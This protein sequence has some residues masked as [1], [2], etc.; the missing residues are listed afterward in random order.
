M[1]CV[2]CNL[3]G[4]RRKATKGK[5]CQKHYEDGKALK[6]VTVIPL[7]D[8]Y[9]SLMGR[10][11]NKKW[12]IYAHYGAK[13][14]TVDPRWHERDAFVTWGKQQGYRKG[15]KLHVEGTVYGPDTCRF[16]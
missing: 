14:Y 11:Y 5:V 10:C 4:V 2:K 12:K 9:Y 1:L 15:M 13:G 6:R 8:Y 7:R 3:E 16:E